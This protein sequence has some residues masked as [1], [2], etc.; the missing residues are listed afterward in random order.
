MHYAKA[1]QKMQSDSNE[2]HLQ[3]C[4]SENLM[5]QREARKGRGTT[6]QTNN[7]N[8]DSEGSKKKI[9]EKKMT[10]KN[11]SYFLFPNIHF[12][13]CLDSCYSFDSRTFTRFA[14]E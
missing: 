12:L 11:F 2:F 13:L 14:F 10:E 5:P 4:Y 7:T 3:V 1:M 8:S 9:W 6:N